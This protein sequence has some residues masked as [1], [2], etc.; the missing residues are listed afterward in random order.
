[1]KNIYLDNAAATPIDSRVLSAMNAVGKKYGNPS[2]YNNTGR[3]A[4]KEIE[5][6]RLSIARFVG[7]RAEEIAFTSS[8]SESNNLALIGSLKEKQGTVL[9]TATEHPSV[10]EPLKSLKKIGLKYVPISKEGSVDLVKFE[11][12]L[13]SDCRLVSVMY[14]NNEIG[15]IQPIKKIAKIITA[16]NNEHG[17]E[18]LFHVD[19]CQATGYLDMNVQHLGVDL[20]TFNGSK[21]YGP[22][23]IGVL[24]VR[25]GV[26]INPIIMGGSQEHNLRA[27]T[28]NTSA[29][30]GLAKAISIIKSTESKKVS[31]LRD[32]TINQ[33]QNNLPEVLINGALGADRLANNA[34]VCI[35][36]LDSENL[37]LE[38]DKYGISA[39]SGSA[40]TSHAVEPSHVLKAIGVPEEYINGAIRFSLGRET[41]KKDIDYLVKSL[42]KIV[43]DLTKR[44]SRLR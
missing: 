7:A 33:I 32:Y 19:A 15:T 41:T 5:L 37:L 40:C 13:S 10:L 4:R 1:M 43:A 20:M 34:S 27:G 44:Y 39:G 2:S 23:G 29:I 11:A 6:A 21:I 42:V 3:L 35:K 28:E 17:T 18:I 24:Y 36:G 14:A 26:K 9:T 22:R 31:A 25:R 30:V 16:Y 38:L 12:M 8:G